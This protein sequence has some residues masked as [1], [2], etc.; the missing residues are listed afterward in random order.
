MENWAV[1]MKRS[2]LK[3]HKLKFCIRLRAPPRIR[4][5]NPQRMWP[6]RSSYIASTRSRGKSS[7]PPLIMQRFPIRYTLL[8][9]FQAQIWALK[10]APLLL[11]FNFLVCTQ[12]KLDVEYL[13]STTTNV[14]RA[15]P[16]CTIPTGETDGWQ[17]PNAEQL[18]L[19]PLKELSLLPSFLVSN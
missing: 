14:E 13:L 16:F 1:K 19:L 7:S 9:L 11:M 17:S 18:L 10:V 8:L 3:N 4:N 15:P 5:T 12:R 6:G 2:L